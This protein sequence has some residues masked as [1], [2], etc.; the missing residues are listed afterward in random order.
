[1]HTRESIIEESS[2]IRWKDITSV[3]C[4]LLTGLCLGSLY[5]ESVPSA[6]LKLIGGV[7]LFTV[8]S[9]IMMAMPR[10]AR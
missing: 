6:L 10:D 9:A 3:A 2:E 4:S 7:A 5:F 1:M 8:Y